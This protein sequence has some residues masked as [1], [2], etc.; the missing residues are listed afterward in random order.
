M[1]CNGSEYLFTDLNGQQV[2][3]EQRRITSV[4]SRSNEW[5]K[6]IG[7]AELQ[8]SGSIRRRIGG[9]MAAKG[10]FVLALA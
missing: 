10:G 4:P 3:V 5:K 8:F 9:M 1:V 2:A 6:A 7:K